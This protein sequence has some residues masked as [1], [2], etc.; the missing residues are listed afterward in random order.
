MF[1]V[2][3]EELLRLRKGLG[4][5]TPPLQPVPVQTP[6]SRLPQLQE[7]CVF[8][9]PSTSR[10]QSQASKVSDKVTLFMCGTNDP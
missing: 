3:L 1:E 6:Q 7:D 4:I 10:L 2:I 5:P 8:S 9:Q